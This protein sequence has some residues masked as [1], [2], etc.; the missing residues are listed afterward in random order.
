[1]KLSRLR[2]GEGI[3]LAAA[4]LLFAS[5]FFSWYGSEVSGQVG[6]IAFGGGAGAG[7]SAWQSLELVSLVL[8]ATIV[9]TVGTTLLRLFGSSWEPAI[10]PSAVVAVL[11]GLSALLVLF[12]I[13]VPPDFGSLGGV[14]VN[15]T[16]ELGVFVGFVTACAVAY[17]GY[18]ALGERGSSFAQIADELGRRATPSRRR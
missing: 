9:V 8:M 15:A 16:L 1:V 11:G 5:M 6:T 12:R 18:R 13:L 3:A 2:A 14:A 10:P 7:G 4:I 17:G